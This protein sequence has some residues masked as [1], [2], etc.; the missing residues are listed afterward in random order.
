MNA[1]INKPAMVIMMVVLL[2]IFMSYRSAQAADPL[3]TRIEIS[4]SMVHPG[5]DFQVTGYLDNPGSEALH[6]V[7]TFFILDVYGILFFWPSWS[8]YAPPASNGIDFRYFDVAAGS[9]LPIDVIP[10]MIWP[11][12]GSQIVSGLYFLGA[13]LHPSMTAILGQVAMVE[14]GYGPREDFSYIEPKTFI[15]GS[16]PD[17]PC[18]RSNET[19]HQVTLTRRF[20]LAAGEI[21]QIEWWD[22]FHNNPAYYQDYY[23]D[24]HWQFPVDSVTWYDTLVYCNR[25]SIREGRRPCYYSDAA[26]T[27]VYDGTPPVGVPSTIYWDQSANGFRL[28]TEAEWEFACRSGTTTAFNSGAAITSCTEDAAIDSLAWYYYNASEHP[29]ST[30]GKSG[31]QTGLHDMHGNI[32]EHVWDGF[33][34]FSPDPVTDPGNP[35]GGGATERVLRGGSFNSQAGE[36]RSAM[37]FTRYPYAQW[38]DIGF[39]VAFTAFD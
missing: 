19:Q 25:R 39:R 15:M 28:P 14:W 20:A 30:G 11:D 5:D 29:H 8:M 4:A 17:E 27:L 10:S 1:H 16:P 12:S 26:Y 38:P 35:V 21:T 7:P 34:P 24:D 9:S 2:A 6:Q 13:M 32:W 31:N 37:R 23:G 36:C 3:G 33:V 22:I 18:R